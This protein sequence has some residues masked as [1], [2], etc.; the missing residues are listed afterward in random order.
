MVKKSID[1]KKSFSSPGR[2]IT[3]ISLITVHVMPLKPLPSM[4]APTYLKGNRL[5][6]P[7]TEPYIIP[8]TGPNMNRIPKQIQNFSIGLPA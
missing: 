4:I 1:C 5:A 2:I 8:P 7:N 3:R 6:R